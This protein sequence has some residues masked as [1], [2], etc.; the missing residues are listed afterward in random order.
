MFG[1]FFFAG[2][3]GSTGYDRNGRWFDHVVATGHE[4]TVVQD[5]CNLASFGLRAARDSIR[6]PLVDRGCG[7]FDFTSVEPFAV[8][9]HRHRIEVVWDLFHY[10]FPEGIDLLGRD[11]A[12]RFADYCYAAARHIARRTDGAC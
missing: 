7:R 12:P 4:R 6:W 10:G 8:A 3:E 2:F 1:S 5:Y 11:F 9:A